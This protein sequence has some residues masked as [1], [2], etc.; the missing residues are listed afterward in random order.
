MLLLIGLCVSVSSWSVEEGD[1][2]G[3]FVNPGLDG[4]FVFSKDYV[5][6]GWIILDFFATDCEPCKKEL[7]ELEELYEELSG[8]V[9]LSILVFA[10]DSAGPAIVKPFFDERP[11]NLKVVIDRFKVAVQ[12]YGVEEIPTVMLV[13]PD[14]IIVFKQTGYSE[15]A[16]AEIRMR[17]T[18]ES[19]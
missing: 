6:K 9:D 5:G 19:E 2:A 12:N 10:T 18:G 15:T 7:P 11:T 17:I 3:V 1:T 16:V 14:G 13:D 4:V 8:E